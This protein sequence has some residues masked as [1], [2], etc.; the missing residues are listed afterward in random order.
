MADKIYIKHNLNGGSFQQPYIARQ[1]ANI[2]APNIRQQ[3]SIVPYTFQSPSTYQNQQPII[4]RNPVNRQNPFIRNAQQPNI[5]SRQNPFIRNAQQ[6]YTY[7]ADAQSPYIANRQNPYPYP[8]NAQTPFT[9]QHQ[10]PSTYRDPRNAQVIVAYQ[11]QSPSTYRDPRSYRNPVSYAYRSPSTYRDPRSYRN[12]VTYQA[13]QP[14]TYQHQSPANINAQESNQQPVPYRVPSTYQAQQRSPQT[15][16]VPSIYQNPFTYQAQRPS[17]YI[18]QSPSTYSAQGQTPYIY[19]SPSTAQVPTSYEGIVGESALSGSSTATSATLANQPNPQPWGSGISNPVWDVYPFGGSTNYINSDPPSGTASMFSVPSWNTLQLATGNPGFNHTECGC[20]MQFD[21]AANNN[22]VQTNPLGAFRISYGHYNSFS[23]SGWSFYYRF[24]M[25]ITDL[26]ANGIIDDT[27][28]FD[29][30]YYASGESVSG[31][32][33][34][35]NC[36]GGGGNSYGF[37]PHVCGKTRGQY[38]NFWSGSTS[39]GGFN[40]TRTARFFKWGVYDST[41]NPVQLT[42]NDVYFG[43]KA[44]KG[45]DTYYTYFHIASYFNGSWSSSP[46]SLRAAYNAGSGGPIIV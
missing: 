25:P 45:T 15:Y 1:P 5:R 35:T 24:Y 29:V 2:Q 43:I 40:G 20:Y 17:P 22:T 28:N 6:T 14:T 39:R 8:A 21:F 41:G 23:N 46:I 30:A 7:Q 11:H 38:Y 10:S 33:A 36:Y 4:Y 9:Y 26:N 19:Q 18:Y 31:T 44:T 3:P 12:P 13:Q 34:Q 27:W 16:R 37:Y 42:S 32:Q